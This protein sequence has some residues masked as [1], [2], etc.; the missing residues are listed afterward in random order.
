V[1]SFFAGQLQDTLIL[2]RGYFFVQTS[3]S[4]ITGMLLRYFNKKKPPKCQ[5]D[6]QLLHPLL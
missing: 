6:L 4:L 3:F 1:L 5:L 2:P